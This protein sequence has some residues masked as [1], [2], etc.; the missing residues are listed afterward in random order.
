[1]S[2][3]CRQSTAGVTRIA[4]QSTVHARAWGR[5]RQRR[6]RQRAPAATRASPSGRAEAPLANGGCF[7]G[8]PRGAGRPVCRRGV[9]RKT[10]RCDEIPSA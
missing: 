1:M 9:P 5:F 7:R 6:R 10:V 2:R 4:T 3:R 8:R